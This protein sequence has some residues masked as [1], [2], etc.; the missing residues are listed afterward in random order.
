M[1][2][3]LKAQSQYKKETMDQGKSKREDNKSEWTKVMRFFTL[4]AVIWNPVTSYDGTTLISAFVWRSR[5]ISI[6]EYKPVGVERY[7]SYDLTWTGIF[8]LMYVHNY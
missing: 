4:G 2:D 3:T 5:E 8:D 7:P 1:K 6:H